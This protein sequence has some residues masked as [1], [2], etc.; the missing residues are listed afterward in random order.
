[1]IR[2]AIDAA[3]TAAGYQAEAALYEAFLGDREQSLAD[4]NHALKIT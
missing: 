2:R 3:E 1:L 4:A